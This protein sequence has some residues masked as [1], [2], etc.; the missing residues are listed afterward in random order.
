MFNQNKSK[1]VTGQEKSS[2]YRQTLS[3]GAIVLAASILITAT[4]FPQMAFAAR[5]LDCREDGGSGDGGSGDGGTKRE[6]RYNGF[7]Y[8]DGEIVTTPGGGQMRCENGV[9]M[10]FGIGY[11]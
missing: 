6:C 3:I 8:K 9:W 1:V 7:Y 2:S 5:C 10:A 11:Q 4:V